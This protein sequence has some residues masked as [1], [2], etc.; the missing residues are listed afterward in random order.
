MSIVTGLIFR[1]ACW[2]AFETTGWSLT[3]G[4]S[5]ALNCTSQKCKNE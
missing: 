4:K 2:L 5:G 1:M 3:A